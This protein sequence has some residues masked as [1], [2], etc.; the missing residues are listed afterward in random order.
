VEDGV[1]KFSVEIE[2]WPWSEDGLA[3]DVDIVIKVPRG[4]EVKE[5]QESAASERKGPKV[6]DLGKKAIMLFSRKVPAFQL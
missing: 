6:Y 3:L 4:R 5:K 2:G 1:I